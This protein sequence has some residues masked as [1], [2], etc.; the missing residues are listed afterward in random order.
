MRNKRWLCWLVILGLAFGIS[1]CVSEDDDD[2]DGKVMTW[3]MLAR[4]IDKQ[5][6]E[7]ALD[8]QCDGQGVPLG[9]HCK[10]QM[11]AALNQGMVAQVVAMLNDCSWPGYLNTAWRPV[12]I[13]LCN[14]DLNVSGTPDIY[15]V[16]TGGE[17]GNAGMIEC[18]ETGINQWR[19][20]YQSC[21]Y[22]DTAMPGG[23]WY[24]LNGVINVY[25]YFT[26]WGE[27]VILINYRDFSAERLGAPLSTYLLNGTEMIYKV[28]DPFTGEQAMGTTGDPD[29]MR[30]LNMRWKVDHDGADV[31]GNYMLR[32]AEDEEDKGLFLFNAD[33]SGVWMDTDATVIAGDTTKM[34]FYDRN[35]PWNGG[36]LGAG[37]KVEVSNVNTVNRTFDLYSESLYG[38]MGCLPDRTGV[39]Y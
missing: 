18:K 1:Y 31:T 29:G 28:L 33:G 23:C 30:L 11:R 38:I 16:C 36:G 14:A 24:D 34:T 26:G 20:T 7:I 19:L 13:D 5:L 2:K 27:S 15:E 4:Y 3:E 32:I 6:G 25:Y 22:D 37:C 17:F 9:T 35:Y 8:G 12:A 21:K 39:R 10:N